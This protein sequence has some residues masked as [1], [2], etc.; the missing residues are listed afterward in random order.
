[1]I[2]IED[3]KRGDR[4]ALGQLYRQYAGKLLNVCRHYIK[5][6][7][8]AEDVLHDA[9]IIIFTSIKD[10]KDTSRLEGWLIAIVRNQCLKYLRSIGQKE[11]PLE[12]ITEILYSDSQPERKEVD[13]QTLFDAIDALPE[14]SR[15]V[16]KLSVLDGYSHIEIGEKLG[17][18]PHSSSSQLFRAKMQLQKM[19]Y[20]HWPLLLLPVFLPVLIYL[21]RRDKTG[22][23]AVNQPETAVTRRTKAKAKLKENRLEKT[24][25]TGTP[26]VTSNEMSVSVHGQPVSATAEA[27]LP[28]DSTR[29]EEGETAYQPDTL[30]RPLT[31]DRA[32][33]DTLFRVP[34]ITIRPLVAQTENR[35]YKPKNKY[36][37][38][39]NLG[40]SSNTGGNTFS[41]LNYLSVIDYANGGAAAK[42]HT[43]NDYIDYMSRNSM[44]MDS[45]ERAKLNYIATN[46]MTEA[47]SSEGLGERATHHRPLTFSL[48][49][50]RQ[51][52]P[53][54]T[55]GTGI[56]YTRLKSEF[57]SPFSGASLN[58]V[59]KIDYIGI[60]LRLTYHIWNKGRFSAYTTGGVTFEMPI[61][62]SLNRQYIVTADSSYTLRETI[63][64]GFQWSVSMG[65]GVQYRLFK[66]F[67]LYVE[68]N[69]F[70]YFGNGSGLETYRTEHPF[71]FTVPFGLR[72]TW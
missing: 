1:M 3:C 47:S 32:I 23:V 19:L 52:S 35:A 4:K 11:V 38:T 18:A 63:R 14:R 39:F 65:L 24:E 51:L 48:S 15:E 55:F 40:Y 58:K 31:P 66:P 42:L 6:E 45:V 64:P 29:K 10:L 62:S 54:W 50:N 33:G 12:N 59:Q 53:H 68:P 49:L 25:Y 44:L 17:I 13:L 16:F 8:V 57:E 71:M 70:Y 21:W 69:M 26:T 43:W 30:L 9:F 34:R 46:N 56:S 5:D 41:D 36:P 7:S 28:T 37:W 20:K 22:D 72:L 67:S 27:I 60:P 61:H 2:E